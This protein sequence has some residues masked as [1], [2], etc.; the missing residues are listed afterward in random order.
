MNIERLGPKRFTKF[1][2]FLLKVGVEK[3]LGGVGKPNLVKHFGPR[4]PL[5]TCVFCL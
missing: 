4:L 2:L 3:S 5:W 1:V